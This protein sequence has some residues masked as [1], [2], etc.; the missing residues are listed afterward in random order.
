MRQHP[1]PNPYGD[2]RDMEELGMPV[3]QGTGLS[4]Q[5]LTAEEL[6]QFIDANPGQS[7]LLGSRWAALD[8]PE[9]ALAGPRT[10]RPQRCQCRPGRP[11]AAWAA[12]AG[13]LWLPPTAAAARSWPPGCVV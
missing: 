3:Y 2:E 13:P 6:Q 1:D 10:L 8:Q 4:V 11:A 12:P 9:R 7:A 5:A